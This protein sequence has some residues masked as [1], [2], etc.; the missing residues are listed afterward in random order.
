MERHA[1]AMEIKKGQK[2]IYRKK[3]GEIWPELTAFL[4]RNGMKNFSIWNTDDL[5]FG[6]YENKDGAVLSAE[7]AEVQKNLIAKMEDTF[8]WISTPGKDMRLMY[9]NFGIV[10]ENKELIRHRMFMTKLKPGCEEEYKA[11][12]DA[13]VEQRGDKIDPGPDSNFSIWS[14]GGY[15]FGYDEID[16]TM[17]VEETPEAREATI[18]WETRQLGIMDWITNDVDWMTGEH[19]SSS[20]RLAWHE[21]V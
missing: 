12:H 15:I 8:T 2:N 6:Y 16:T 1:F 17:E 18:A 20:V 9:H 4:D 7:E 21:G 13:L 11:R 19:H 14:A 3:L 10:R 5:I